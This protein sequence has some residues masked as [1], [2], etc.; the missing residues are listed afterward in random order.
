MLIFRINPHP[1]NTQL[2][3]A[4]RRFSEPKVSSARTH[5]TLDK[6]KRRC[7]FPRASVAMYIYRG[8]KRIAI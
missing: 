6:E 4:A 8:K 5:V 1:S 7:N 3:Y 2:A